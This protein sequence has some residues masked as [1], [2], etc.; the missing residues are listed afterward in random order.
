MPTKEELE[1]KAAE[2]NIEGRS[3]MN[4]DELE[5]AIAEAEGG[6]GGGDNGGDDGGPSGTHDN[7]AVPQ[8]EQGNL[9][10]NEVVL[11]G[12]SG[13]VEVQ[14]VWQQTAAGKRQVKQWYTR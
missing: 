7:A 12:E 2:L 3:T 9:D 1:K 11:G 13:T 10:P 14:P 8:Q 5:A 6:Q 4:K